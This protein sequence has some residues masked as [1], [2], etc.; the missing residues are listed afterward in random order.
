[1]K[2]YII[3]TLLIVLMSGKITWSQT[4]KPVTTKKS[5]TKA[6]PKTTNKTTTTTTT[7]TSSSAVKPPVVEKKTTTTTTTITP[8]QSIPTSTTTT[9]SSG[10]SKVGKVKEDKVEVVKEPKYKKIKTPSDVNGSSKRVK[11][12]I[13]V[14]ASQF[15]SFETGEDVAFSPGLNAGLIINILLN[16]TFAIQPEVLYAM[17]VQQSNEIAGSFEKLTTGSIL[18]PITLD[19][20]LGKGSTKFMVK[21]GGYANYYLSSTYEEAVSTFKTSIAYDLTG[22]NRFSYGTVLGIGVKLNKSILIEA[23][24]FYD[25]KNTNNKSMVATLGIGYL[26]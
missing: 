13:R 19:I 26:F 8:P 11:F 20:N 5:T 24:S 7:T 21:V 10:P 3:A 12:G 15:I 18:T 4:K 22:T 2:N 23:R 16:E 9:Q 25:L 14:E 6:Y 17:G 1:M